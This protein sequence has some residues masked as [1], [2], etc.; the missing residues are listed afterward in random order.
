MFVIRFCLVGLLFA[1]AGIGGLPWLAVRA[2]AATVTCSGGNLAA[3]SGEDLLVTGPCTV[4]AGTYRYGNVNVYGGGS[5]TFQDAVIDFWTSGLLVENGSSLVAGSP[6][7]PIGT[8]GGTLTIHLYGAASDSATRS[9]V[10]QSP[11]GTCGVPASTWNSSGGTKVPLPGFPANQPVDYFYAYESLPYDG[12]PAMPAYFGHK[13]LAASYGASVQLFG[14]KGACYASA[15]GESADPANPTASSSGLSWGRLIGSLQPGSTRLVIDRLVDWTAGDHI[16]VTTTD[17]LPGHSEELVIA[18]AAQDP[19]SGTTTLTFTNAVTGQ[20]GV[21]YPHNGEAYSLATVPTRLNLDIRQAETRAAVGLLSRSIRIVSEGDTL[22]QPFPAETASPPYAFG[23]HTIVRQ[24]V[25]SFQVQGVEFRQLGQGGRIAH[26]PVHFHMVRDAPPQTFVKDCSVNESMTRWYTVHATQNVTLARNVGWK[27]I[28]HG[29]YIED[30]TETD[31]RF[32]SNLGV[33][34]RAAVDNAQNPRQVPGILA[35]AGGPAGSDSVPY[36]SDYNHPSVFWIMNGWNDF[37]Y[38]MAVGAG[39][40]G[41]CYWLVPGAISGPSRNQ[42]WEAYASMQAGLGRAGTTPLKSFTGNFCS[43]AMMSFNTVGNTNCPGIAAGEDSDPIQPVTNPLAPPVPAGDAGDPTAGGYYPIV[44]QSGGRFA[45]RC[46]GDTSD[47][48]QVP[49]CADG[50]AS[51]KCMVTVLDHYTSSFHW[52]ET[53]FAAIWLRPQWYLAIG[54]VLSDVQNGGMTFVTGGDYTHSS[55]ISGYWALA[56]KNVFI[57]QTQP[58]NPFAS[59]A[60]PVNGASGLRCDSS[61]GS[62][63]L[64]KD[65]GLLLPLSTF[66]VNQRL[67]NIYDGPSYQESNA[68]LDINTVDVDDCQPGSSGTCFTSQSMYGRVQGMPFDSTRSQCYLPNAAIGWKQPNGFYYPPAFESDNLFFANVDIRHFVIEPLFRPDS[69]TTDPVATQAQYCT[70]NSGL[71]T[72]FT[73]VDRQ[74]VLNDDDGSLTGLVNTVSVNKD[75]FFAAPVETSECASEDTVKTSPYDYVTTVVYPGCAMNGTCGQS[76]AEWDA[77]CSTPQCFGV[78]LYRQLLRGDETTAPAIRMMGAAIYQRSNLTVNNGTYYIDT[79][80]GAAAQR[81]F[82]SPETISSLSVF[83]AGQTYYVFNLYAKPSTAQ[84]YQ[85]YVGSGFDPA[86]DLSLVR[87]DIATAPLSFAPGPWPQ[88]WRQSYDRATGILTVTLNLASFQ[89]QFDAGRAAS[90]QPQS[91][92][93]W[94]GASSACE[95]SAQLQQDDPALYAQCVGNAAAGDKPVCSWAVRDLDCPAGGCFGF[96]FKLPAGF[97][98]DPSPNPRPAATAFP[99]DTIWN[100]PWTPAT[101]N[102]AGSCFNP[103]LAPVSFSDLGGAPGMTRKILLGTSGDD[104][105]NGTPGDDIIKGYDGNDTLTGFGGH[106]WISGGKGHDTILGG[107]GNDTLNGGDGDDTVR[108]GDG[109]DVIHAGSG[110]DRLFGEKGDDVIHGQKGDDQ[111]DG[112]SGN[113]HLHGGVDTDRC[114][115]GERHGGCESRR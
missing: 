43:T 3:G 89:A 41:T 57:G 34:A 42:K 101:P 51:A 87:A 21:Q 110:N 47:C 113:D 106:D 31:N 2:E 45:T 1:A 91:F 115:N 76:G 9:L 84:T 7:A 97:Q 68:Y 36:L 10:C 6:T 100:V 104:V 13:V 20:G 95:C 28:G 50:A 62:H 52:T 48:S 79:T 93:S 59:A 5:L 27:S 96:S 22:N 19:G 14:R 30:G 46:D 90:C 73:D 33:F 37:Q 78:P 75:P 16:V 38:N 109:H 98:T 99:S 92:C 112:G 65:E 83:G 114:R 49:I 39:T 67:F 74:T 54:G 8:A 29:Y 94:N 24:G 18:T 107:P 88:A 11:G 85:I 40:C 80:V 26:Y 64:L 77:A 86:T 15:C 25:Q 23:G 12:S 81:A 72:G 66:A 17:Y 58:D 102:L 70:W 111:L 55:I 60:G 4:A 35:G 103:A 32:Y 53:N 44:S 71:F 108:A 63:C 105:L 69:F 56:R 61:S 82:N